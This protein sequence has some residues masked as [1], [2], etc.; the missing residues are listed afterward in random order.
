MLECSFFTFEDS[1]QPIIFRIK[2]LLYPKL[3]LTFENSKCIKVANNTL[4][5][6]HSPTHQNNLSNDTPTA[7]MHLETVPQAQEQSMSYTIFKFA[8]TD[9]ETLTTPLEANSQLK[10]QIPA[11]Q[12]KAQTLAL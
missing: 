4:I 10:S 11:K 3:Y 12:N 8:A 1:S 9:L 7:S 2:P 5:P 6:N